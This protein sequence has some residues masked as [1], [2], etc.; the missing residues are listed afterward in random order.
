MEKVLITLKASGW[1]LAAVFT[2]SSF[3]QVLLTLNPRVTNLEERMAGCESK[4]SAIEIKL[5]TLLH[6]S[7]ETG[8]DIKDIYHLIMERHR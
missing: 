5:D 2:V 4:V 8:K 7:T 3:I 6:Q 1:I